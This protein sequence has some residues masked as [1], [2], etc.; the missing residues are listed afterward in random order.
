MSFDVLQ[1]MQRDKMPALKTA[2]HQS[3]EKQAASLVS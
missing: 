3:M 2:L 1:L